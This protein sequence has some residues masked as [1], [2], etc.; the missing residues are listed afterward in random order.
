MP[1]FTFCGEREHKTTT[2]RYFSWILLQVTLTRMPALRPISFPAFSYSAGDWPRMLTGNPGSVIVSQYSSST[3]YEQLYH[4]HSLPYSFWETKDSSLGI[5]FV[6]GPRDQTQPGSLSLSLSRSVGT[7]R[8][9]PWERGWPA[10][11]AKTS[12]H[13][14]FTRK[15]TTRKMHKNYIRDPSGLFSI[16]SRVSLSMT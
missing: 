3:T 4:C 11:R 8:R 14:C 10:R 12:R 7:G 6:L 16:I 5:N 1:N 15:Y 9:K 2:L 13:E